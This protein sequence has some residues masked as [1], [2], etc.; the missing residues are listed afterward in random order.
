MNTRK[1]ILTG[2]LVAA[3]SA[4]GCASV[5]AGMGFDEVG[6]TVEER[7]G[8]RV[9]WNQ[10][11]PADQAVEEEVSS[12]LN[13]ELTA[14]AAVQIALLN[15]R[16]LQATYEELN[17]AQADLVSAG[18]LRNPVFDAEVRFPTKGGGTGLELA[19]VQ[20]FID[21]LYIPLRKGVARSAFEAAKLRVAGAAIDLAG[22]VRAAFYSAQASEQSLELRKNVVAATEAAYALADRLRA[23]GN[24]TELDVS[25]ERALFE[26]SKLDLRTAELDVLRSRERLNVLVGL[27]GKQ[28]GWTMPP[29]LPEPSAEDPDA[30]GLERRAIERSLELAIARSEIEQA[31]Q[32]LGIARPLGLFSDVELGA[33]AEREGDGAWAVGPAFS[34][35]LPVFN[36]GQPAVAAARATLRSESQRYV[37]QA[38]SLR[39]QVRVAHAAV[40]A[41]REIVEY[42]AKI[43]M[44]LRQRIVDHT[45]LRYNAMQ[46]GAFQLLQAKRDQI[47]T[48]SDYIRAL[49][50]YWLAYTE[51]EQLLNG[52]MTSF[53]AIIDINNEPS[54][55]EST[56]G[57]A[58]H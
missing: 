52:R 48:G 41:A 34:I 38:V 31:A 50:E 8:K 35:P 51:R 37:A 47:E 32:T 5:Q 42:Y 25:N 18:L 12:L 53:E 13:E 54:S 30:K 4:S 6:R 1:L 2:A 22:Q 43:V 46:I 26:Q 39:S 15:N 14:D 20:D 9:H 45:Q 19:V 49:L 17:I 23:A 40:T 3:L 55:S 10:G 27:W 33:S 16:I 11:T 24:I 7:T 28:T 57:G 44:P 56:S 21:I 58:A 36:Q 29:R